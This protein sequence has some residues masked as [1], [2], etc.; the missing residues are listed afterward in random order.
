MWALSIQ[1]VLN[2]HNL[3]YWGCG[4]PRYPILKRFSLVLLYPET[5]CRVMKLQGNKINYRIITN[6]DHIAMVQYQMYFRHIS[7]EIRK[8]NNFIS[9]SDS[10]ILAIV[11]DRSK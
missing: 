7:A 11:T 1:S 9:R 2:P 6:K 10:S 4:M 8:L 3:Y 5:G